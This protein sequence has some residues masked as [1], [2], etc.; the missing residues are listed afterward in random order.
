MAKT[1]LKKKTKNK[2]EGLILPDLKTYYKAIAIKM[3]W[4]LHRVDIENDGIE[5]EFRGRLIYYGKFIFSKG[6]KITYWEK[7]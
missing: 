7:E 2:V 3:V 4:Y 5:L 1:I 6:A